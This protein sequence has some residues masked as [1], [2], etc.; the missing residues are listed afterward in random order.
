MTR[1]LSLIIHLICF[2]YILIIGLALLGLLIASVRTWMEII[3][4]SV[5][6]CVRNITSKGRSSSRPSIRRKP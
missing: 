2:A 3:F 4:Y 5:R 6:R 1:E